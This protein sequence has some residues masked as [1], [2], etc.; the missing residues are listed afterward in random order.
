MWKILLA[1]DLNERDYKKIKEDVKLYG[2]KIN[3]YLKESKTNNKR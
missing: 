2:I 1:M 3:Q